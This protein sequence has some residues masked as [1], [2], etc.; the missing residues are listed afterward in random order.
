M[1]TTLIA[2][3]L[4]KLVFQVLVSHKAGRVAESH[5]LRRAQ[6]PGFFAT[7]PAASS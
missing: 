2:V 4:A 5:R 6:L 1:K 3:D 7:R